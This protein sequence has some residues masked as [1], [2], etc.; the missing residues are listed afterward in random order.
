MAELVC[1]TG[2]VTLYWPASYHT[3]GAPVLVG[4]ATGPR[5]RALSAAGAERVPD[6]V[7]DDLDR[8]FPRVRPGRLVEDVRFVDWLTDPL[9]RGG[10]TF[11]PPG[12]ADARARLAAS[13][14][15]AL[16]WAGSATVSSPIADTVEAAYL[17]GLQA[18]DEVAARLL[19]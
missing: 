9:A 4:Y 10:Y 1:G 7:R 17:S 19:Q 14:T 12:A 2:P 16:V 8:L 18:A 13:D 11:L 5:A 6:L 3:A 15:G